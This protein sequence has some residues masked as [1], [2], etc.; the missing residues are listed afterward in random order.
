MNDKTCTP[1]PVRE[2]SSSQKPAQTFRIYTLDEL[3]ELPILDLALRPPYGLWR[4][5]DGR[6]VLFDRCYCPMYSRPGPGA[7]ATVADPDEYVH[8][9]ETTEHFWLDG[10]TQPERSAAT[11]RKLTRLLEAWGVA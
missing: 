7:P 11:P 8:G 1:K 4:C 5:E 10:K 6:E 2:A 9:I 3:D